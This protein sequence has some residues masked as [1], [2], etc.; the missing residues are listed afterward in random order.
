[1]NV[2]RSYEKELEDIRIANKG[3]RLLP[4]QVVDYAR[5]RKNSELHRCF[6]WEDSVA[7]ERWRLEQAGSL[8]RAVIRV[9][10]NPK[11]DPIRTRAY[12][13]LPVDRV[14]NLG[15]RTI[16][17][18][19]SEPESEAQMLSALRAEMEALQNRYQTLEELIPIFEA[20]IS[21]IDEVKEKAATRSRRRKST[22]DRPRA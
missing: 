21:E 17:D 2:S 18:V 1:M 10:P 11:G 9:I 6:E 22:E 8:I 14:M 7:A 16:E 3:R 13:S 19:M 15:Y 20:V 12:V 4:E 5:K